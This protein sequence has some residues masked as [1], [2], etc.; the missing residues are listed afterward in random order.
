MRSSM[1]HVHL[2]TDF[3]RFHL[4]TCAAHP[5]FVVMITEAIK[6]LK[7]RSGSSAPA[8]AKV[9][10]LIRPVSSVAIVNLA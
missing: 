9:I 3:D 1:L 6:A 8:I 5:P 2:A 4:L 10:T 7:D